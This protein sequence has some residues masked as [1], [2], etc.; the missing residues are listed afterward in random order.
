MVASHEAGLAA[1]RPIERLVIQVDG[2]PSV[3]PVEASTA[4]HITVI[5][6]GDPA[7]PGAQLTVVKSQREETLP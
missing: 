7:A 5:A 6:T 2:P 3:R 1:P 4:T